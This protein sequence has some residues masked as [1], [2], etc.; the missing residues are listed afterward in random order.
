MKY[1]LGWLIVC[2]VAI[3]LVG[4]GL[5]MSSDVKGD[6]V[7]TMTIQQADAQYKKGNFRDAL[8]IYQNV[9]V[10]ADI[11]VEQVSDRLPRVIECLN[12]L[13]RI[14]EIDHFLELL[15]T[16]HDRRPAIL[17]VI[18]TTYQQLDHNGYVVSGEFSRGY[19]RG[20]GRGA[21]YVNAFARDRVRALQLY[22]T[23]FDLH[24]D[25]SVKEKITDA[26][27]FLM[28]F[29]E[30]VITVSGRGDLTT[31]T[32]LETL[33]D[34]GR[35]G[36]RGYRGRP[37]S[38]GASIEEDGTPVFFKKPESF[39]AAKNDGERYRFLLG[40]AEKVAEEADDLKK[41]NQVKL[42]YA[43][44]LRQRYGVE[45]MLQF[46]FREL[47]AKESLDDDGIPLNEK[48]GPFAVASL[49][50]D[51]TIA[52]LSNGVKRFELPGDFNHIADLKEIA[53][54]EERE[55][56]SRALGELAEIYSNRMQFDRAGACLEES[57]NRFPNDRAKE[58]RPR[59]NQIVGNWGEFE[60]TETSPAGKGAVINYRFRN[61]TEVAITAHALKIEALL[62]DMKAYLKTQPR[63]LNN[64]GNYQIE[65]IGNQIVRE[66]RRKYVG[67]EVANWIVELEPRAKH[68]DKRISIQTPLQKAGA[69][70]VEAKM[71]DGN[72]SRVVMWVA[73]TAIV[74]K[75]LHQADL[76]YVADAASGKPIAKANVEFVGFRYPYVDDKQRSLPVQFAN[77]SEKTDENGLLIIEPG[78]LDQEM[79]WMAIARTED[80]RLAYL[81][82]Q[83]IW[84]QESSV[85]RYDE[86]KAFLVTDRPVY[87]PG[88]KMSFQTWLRRADY[89]SDEGRS[90]PKEGEK[91]SV[92]IRDPKGEIVHEAK[93]AV[94][95]YGSFNGEI[96][97]PDDA[98]LGVY[99]VSVPWE[100][101][102]GGS[103]SYRVEEYKKP[104]YE[105]IIESPEKPVSLGET[106]TA[107][108]RAK[109][110]F[111]APVTHANVKYKVSRTKHTANWYPA[112]RW[113]W[114]YGNGYRWMG[115]DY[116]WYPGWGRWGCFMPHPTWWNS[117][118]DPP[119]IVVEDE[120]EIG[121]DGTVKIE[122]DTALAMAIYGE[123]QSHRYEISAEVVDESRRTI[124]GTG[125]VLV[126]A[127][128]FQVTT[129][130]DRGYYN[131][132]QPVSVTAKVQTLDRKPIVGVGE[133]ELY[134]ISYSEEG[135]HNEKLVKNWTEKLDVHGE[136]KVTFNATQA[137]QYRVAYRC[138]SDEGEIE[139]GATI[140]IVRG[141]QW[142]SAEIT[143]NDLE[144]V[145][146]QPTY[147]VGE[148]AK[149][150]LNANRADTTVL[151][152]VRAKDGVYPK[153]QIVT[154]DGKSAVVDLPILAADMPNFF[155]EAMTVGGARV[156]EVTKELFVP[157]ADRMLDVALK[158]DKES[159][160]PGEEAT[161]TIT[162]KDETGRPVE[163]SLAMT[164]YDKSV[165][166]ISGGSNVEDIREFFWK[167]RQSHYP[168][169][170]DSLS[171]YTPVLYK[172][173]DV[174]MSSL[175]VFG[176]IIADVSGKRLSTTPQ[177]VTVGSAVGG[178]GGGM[179]MQKSMARGLM[180]ADAMADPMAMNA[181]AGVSDDQAA[182]NV[183]PTIRKE[184]AD[185]AFWVANLVSNSDG[186]ATATFKMPENLTSWTMKTWAVGD[187]TRV[188]QADGSAVTA[189]NVIVRLQAPR[190]F[191]ETDEVVLSANVHNYL[192]TA[193]K[194]TVELMLEG[195]CLESGDALSQSVEIPA[196]GEVRVDW[197]VK[198]TSPG[199]A[200][201]TMKALTDEESDAMQM[202]FPVNVY[203]FLKMESFTGNMRPEET[204]E[205]FTVSVPADRKV[206]QSRLE[207][208]YSPS[209]A[210]AMVDALP[211]LADYPYGCTEQTLNRFLPTVITLRSLQ[212]MKIDLAKVREKQVNFNSQEL[213]DAKERAKD[214]KRHSEPNPVFD[215]QE[216]LKMAKA[217]LDRLTAM[218]LAD[219]GWG[220]F[221]GVRESSSAHTT[222]TVVHGLNIALKNDLALVPGMHEQGV[223]WLETY[224][225]EQVRLLKL[226][227][228]VREKKGEHKR[229]KMSA[230]QLD[231]FVFMTLVEA[232]RQNAEMMEYLFRDRSRLS[233]YCLAQLGLALKAI[234]AQD[235]LDVV[236]ENLEQYVV[237][238][239]ENQTAYLKFQDGYSWWNWFGNDVEANAY[240]LKLL[241]A[242]DP[243]G[244]NTSR[245]VKYVLNNRKGGSYWNNT[246]D[247]AL[248]IEAVNDYLVATKEGQQDV[249][250]IVRIDGEDVKT[251]TISPETLFDFDQ[252]VVLMGEDV[253]TGEHTIELVKEGQGPLYW[254]AYLTY[255][256]REDHIEA[257]G[258]ELKVDRVFY[259]LIRV[260]DATATVRNKLGQSSSVAVEKYQRRR[261]ENL[262]ELES[263][264]LI[265]VEF[266]IESKND[267]EYILVEDHKAA[268]C[269]AVEVQ[270]G[271]LDSANGA[272]VEFRD[273]KVAMFFTR[274]PRG[275]SSL[276]YR[277]KAEI[278]GKFT[279]LPTRVEGMY[280]PELK[281][282]SDD[283][284]MLIAE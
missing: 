200:V 92:E 134:A 35:S 78:R 84:F 256:S 159:Y 175:G 94:D 234:D 113:D 79:Q 101:G 96:T 17:A 39:N 265:E 277:L 239:Q 3:G 116:G 40:E 140:F 15:V 89:L 152:F 283:L 129:W 26:Y 174:K 275:T 280:A 52:K 261:L 263:G 141:D 154:L 223:E 250:V 51:E 5:K 2:G 246:R 158:A 211:Y 176:S 72:V 58:Y 171:H 41:V 45:T 254:N 180:Q 266:T 207:I 11:P 147:Q 276:S 73:D 255:F 233:V 123:S 206:E 148:T 222:A 208:R 119:E 95:R 144:M 111:G 10:A 149:I 22:K 212:R 281:G 220:W 60:P 258:L 8:D 65:E 76:Y 278:P 209:L 138:T 237:V 108:V 125:N 191:V 66:N 7:Q 240:Y 202:T 112:G 36:G 16:T 216:V 204:G 1:P 203:G 182:G 34:Y 33:P 192:S 62:G 32:D 110:Y 262:A 91:F 210:Y 68:F 131:V 133:F 30:A 97:I 284:K 230:D 170:A 264:D 213:G 142:Q 214:W 196:D 194:T 198:V 46:G 273:Q 195:G 181:E 151:L 139:E 201:V 229:Y 238:D 109:Y 85:D 54:T 63:N 274:L 47:L 6:L 197:R 143:F 155:V 56:S 251:V 48:T 162:V 228:E 130:L 9:L 86:S 236:L 257:T 135:K 163:G 271:Y 18:A 14:D 117:P 279:A 19:H 136:A 74:K 87:R 13:S 282:N 61:G 106:I 190:F 128:P 260:E 169:T 226:G 189:K 121:E 20:G 21:E 161:V 150:L 178:F 247:T 90:C 160:L 165:E 146:E 31:L 167:F 253:T 272:Y 221:S 227:D 252:S 241:S 23:S 103:I 166:Y 67:A 217:G 83:N 248:C 249:R 188:G 77:I 29:T 50:D 44:F 269:E 244:E 75:D 24:N 259:Q 199:E 153:P 37:S 243:L 177:Q 224:Q 215:E 105:V 43:Q 99:T 179:E 115:V 28:A 127:E 102:Y 183:T 187:G 164:V 4:Q 268:G 107:T 104:E 186:I 137:G 81:G 122:I 82:F 126:A 25:A 38:S 64:F 118:S 193:K 88:Q 100:N 156:H 57:L 53:K 219:G 120:V 267:Y 245:L 270:S 172:N 242:V 235:K 124:V 157:P 70:L 232:G 114:F 184:F 225:N 168:Q 231:A 59:L 93:H 27:Q 69:Y 173:D 12:R 71:Q 49:N 55:T 98:T 42:R 80:G 205:V 132:G 185:T 218:Q 145:I